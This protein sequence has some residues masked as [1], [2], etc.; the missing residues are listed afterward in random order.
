MIRTI[1]PP[2]LSFHARTRKDS[3][4]FFGALACSSFFAC[5][6]V[7]ISFKNRKA[8]SLDI[9]F[10]LLFSFFILWVGPRRIRFS[11]VGSFRPS[12]RL[13][14]VLSIVYT[15][16]KERMEASGE[17]YIRNAERLPERQNVCRTLQNVC[18]NVSH[19]SYCSCCS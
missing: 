6:F 4:V 15:Q 2:C 12:R 1:T 14:A 3:S 18:Q 8:L 9:V 16:R 10:P 5:S 7:T 11:P 13:P 17:K 19:C